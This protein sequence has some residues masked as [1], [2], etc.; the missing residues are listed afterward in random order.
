M[1]TNKSK[2]MI[3]LE[4]ETLKK[5]K[6]LAEENERSTTQEI[7]YLVKQEIKKY[8]EEHGSINN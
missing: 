1:P 3:Y 8:E 7:V 6:F 2:F 5:I 4:E